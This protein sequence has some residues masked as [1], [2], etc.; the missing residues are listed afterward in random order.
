MI[1]KPELRTTAIGSYPHT[2]INGLFE[3]LH[4]T[5]PE[6][7]IWPQLPKLSFLEEM[8]NQYSKRLPCFFIDKEK[9]KSGF[10]TSKDLPGELDR[11][12]TKVLSDDV[13]YFGLDSEYSRGFDPYREYLKGRDNSTLFA[14]KGQIVGPLTHGILTD[15]V[16][17]KLAF[18]KPDLYDAIVKNCIMIA[19]WQIKKLSEFFPHVI[20]FLDEPSLSV[21]GSG[22][23]SVEPEQTYDSFREVISAIRDE[24]GI[25]G[26]HCCG[27]ADW[28]RLI[29][30]GIDII[31][32][33]AD[34]EIVSDK[35]I[36]STGLGE[37]VEAGKT[38][39]W[40]IVPTF[41]DKT[42]AA[43]IESVEKKFVDLL[44]E[45]KKRGLKEETLL[46]QS[47]IT[48][49]CGTGTLT[50]ELAEKVMRLTKEISE[51]IR[52]EFRG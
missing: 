41:V 38:I 33:D 5:I 16:D 44:G 28:S 46:E 13:D 39:A 22:F 40:G 45:L 8:N 29:G 49:S 42:K 15:S 34:D 17:G 20:I 1:K 21:I 52:G 4:E 12:Y 10:D 26:M 2:E 25:P 14:V 36:N 9:R 6:L 35:F 32:F 50:V 30:L 24:G 43:T 31:N 7:P 18:Y 48:P 51:R 27:N 3:L 11:F 37:Y 23:Y 19:R 47:L